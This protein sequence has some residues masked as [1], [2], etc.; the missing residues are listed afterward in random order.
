M[1]DLLLGLWLD[2]PMTNHTTF[3]P[4]TFAD[5]VLVITLRGDDVHTVIE[6]RP[7]TSALWQR[8][9][10]YSHLA[11]YLYRLRVEVPAEVQAL[12]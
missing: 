2:L 8:S 9:Q 7:E 5:D 4:T 1:L 6:G 3:R 10:R 12:L 11:S